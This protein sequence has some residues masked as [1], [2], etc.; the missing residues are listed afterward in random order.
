[1]RLEHRRAA[2]P[3]VSTGIAHALNSMAD[4]VPEKSVIAASP[5]LVLPRHCRAA[6]AAVPGEPRAP[7]AG[8]FA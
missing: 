8:R 4:H 6:R 1:M 5:K 3:F 7:F 2:L